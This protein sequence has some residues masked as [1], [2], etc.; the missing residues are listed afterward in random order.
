MKFRNSETQKL[1]SSKPQKSWILLFLLILAISANCQSVESLEKKIKSIQKDIKLA[2]K[3]LKET[4]KNKEATINQ[5]SL[6]QTQINQRETLI[7]TCPG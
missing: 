2:E 6:L 5:V 3:L 7:K 4:S 1:R